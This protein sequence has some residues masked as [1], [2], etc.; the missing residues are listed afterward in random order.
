MTTDFWGRRWFVEKD[1]FW[2]G[3]VI[4]LEVTAKLLDT[5]SDFQKI[6]VYQTRSMGK[7]LV[8]DGA[9]QLTERD[10]PAYHEMFVHV[11]MNSATSPIEKVLIVGAGDGGILRELTKYP[12][13][14]K[15]DMVEIDKGVVDAAKEFLPFTSCGFNDNR[16]NL[17]IGDGAAFLESKDNEYD[18]IV[19]DSS[20]P[21]GPAATLYEHKFYSNMFKALKSDGRAITQAESFWFHLDKTIKPLF[22]TAKTIFPSVEYY[23]T[24]VPTYPSGMIGYMACSKSDS[25]SIPRIILGKNELE[26]LKYYTPD[27]HKSAFMLPK[28]FKDKLS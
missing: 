7:L 21:I 9:I 4:A 3:S 24:L 20:D 10:E 12:S 18:V 6:E 23:Y 15:I 5:Q 28:Q 11:P 22:D 27:V 8:L 13:I 2:P 26:N 19:V 25:L 16:V 17:V 1:E 14:K